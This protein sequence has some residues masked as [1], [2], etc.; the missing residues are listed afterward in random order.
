MHTHTH[1]THTCTAF[2]QSCVFR[3]RPNVHWFNVHT[4]H[5]MFALIILYPARYIEVLLEVIM[6]VSQGLPILHYTPPFNLAACIQMC[7]WLPSVTCKVF[8][9][10]KQD[11]VFDN[12]HMYVYMYIRTSQCNCV[13][14]ILVFLQNVLSVLCCRTLLL[15]R[16]R[17]QPSS[18][19]PTRSLRL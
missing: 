3:D 8:L 5:I 10:L 17:R 11:S 16:R 7:V 2:T 12:E 13:W 18:S 19:V 4:E 1:T 14:R 9:L 15:P 6:D